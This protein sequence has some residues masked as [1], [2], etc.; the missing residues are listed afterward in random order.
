MIEKAED[1]I[2]HHLIDSVVLDQQNPLALVTQPPRHF[3]IDLLLGYSHLL[4]AILVA[5]CAHLSLFLR[6]ENDCEF[7]RLQ[8]LE[9]EPQPPV[10]GQIFVVT[11]GSLLH[12]LPALC[13]IGDEDD[14]GCRVRL[15][16]ENLVHK[17]DDLRY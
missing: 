5:I 13:K 1:E 16:R 15:R 11:A 12:N 3:F 10:L 4:C 2:T 6:I 14:L 9:D 17:G 7:A 8:W